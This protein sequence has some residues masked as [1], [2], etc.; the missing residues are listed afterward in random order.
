MKIP[1]SSRVLT[2]RFIVNILATNPCEL[3]LDL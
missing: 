2:L 3:E 1:W